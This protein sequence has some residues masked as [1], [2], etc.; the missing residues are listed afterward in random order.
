M[1]S[2]GLLEALI[3]LTYVQGLET[4]DTFRSGT[5]QTEG[6]LRNDRSH[7]APSCEQ[8][9]ADH[10]AAPV[11]LMPRQDAT[12][13]ASG[14]PGTRRRSRGA[15]LKASAS[16]SPLVST[17]SCDV[18]A[19]AQWTLCAPSNGNR[20]ES[21]AFRPS[22]SEWARA[23]AIGRGPG[24]HNK[25]HARKTG[26]RAR[27]GPLSW[28]IVQSYHPPLDRRRRRVRA[29]T[30]AA[31]SGRMRRTPSTV[32]QCTH[33]YARARFRRRTTPWISLRFWLPADSVVPRPLCCPRISRPRAAANHFA[34]ALT[35]PGHVLLFRRDHVNVRAEQFKTRRFK[36]EKTDVN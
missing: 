21:R 9:T 8:E 2:L 14:G 30:H 29:S 15:W 3:G 13:S 28:W 5:R 36:L 33:G 26:G 27:A 19:S 1:T 23:L 34:R 18:G 10:R 11:C 7:D 24:W 25:A 4:C 32:R 31:D 16:R 12:A 20:H 22:T 6:P 17:R 35:G